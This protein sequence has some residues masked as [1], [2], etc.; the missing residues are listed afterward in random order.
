MRVDISAVGI[1]FIG[2]PAV[3]TFNGSTP[4]Q[5]SPVVITNDE[6][7]EN[8]ETFFVQLGSSDDAINIFVS[9]ATVTITDDDCEYCHQD[10]AAAWV[11]LNILFLCTVVT[12]RLENTSYRTSE[13]FGTVTVCAVLEGLTERGLQVTLFTLS[14][15]AAG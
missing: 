14:N 10:V 9:S 11:M 3:L 15:T 13:E 2:T 4:L 8:N 6:I 5:C 1:D 12:V 7:V